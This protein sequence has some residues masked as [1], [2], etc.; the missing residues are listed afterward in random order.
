MFARLVWLMYITV[1]TCYIITQQQCLHPVPGIATAVSVVISGSS[2]VL[3]LV[4][5]LPNHGTHKL[6]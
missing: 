2:V 4:G 5:V 1:R 3:H 6:V